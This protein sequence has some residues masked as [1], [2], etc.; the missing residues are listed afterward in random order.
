MASTFE[1]ACRAIVQK[2]LAGEVDDAKGL[3]SAKLWASR[4]FKLL[5]VPSN[6]Q[7][8]AQAS[9]QEKGKLLQLL[10]RK[11]VR[12]ASGVSII[13]VMTEPY[14]CPQSPPCIYCPGG[15]SYGTPQSYT[16]HEPAGLRAIQ[17]GFN[18][19]KQVRARI[20]QLQA[21]GHDVDKVELIVLGGTQ[22]AQP[23][24]Y[25]KWFT[26]EC[27]NALAGT[28]AS[29]IEEAQEAAERASIRNV[30]ITFETRPDY[31]KE[32]HVDLLL[33]L[34]ATRVELGVQTVY[35]DIYKFIKRGHT[36]KDVAEATRILKDSG[37]AIIY[38]MMP[39]LPG[40]D[41]DRDLDMFSKLF[42]DPSFRPDGLKIYPCLVIRGT[43]LHGRWRAGKF[44]AMTAEKA[45]K[46]IA[47]VKRSMPKWVRVHRIQRDIPAKLIEAGV[48]RGNLAQ[49]VEGELEKLGAR[50]RCIRCR[51][52]GLM[53]LRKGIQ[54]KLEDVKLL[55]ESYGASEGEEIFLSFEDVE[56]DIL[57]GFLR[58]RLPS[59]KAHYPKVDENIAVVRELHVY[60]PL[61]PVGKEAKV[62]DW[63]HRGW[64]E[65]LLKEAERAARERGARKI[66]ILSGIG[67]RNY[68]RRFD[69]RRE[70]PYMVKELS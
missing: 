49:M 6:V 21:I 17:E 37:F 58:L 27:L 19:H 30:G 16:G 66:A 65:E 47:E 20:G 15:P 39:G 62:G 48:K 68:Y 13:T 35:D 64:G 25:L 55:E 7:I 43:E 2:I 4:E 46:L 1:E 52:V 67:V 22:L 18:P 59:A 28:R 57:I 3:N 70:G 54:P 33:E 53:T 31:A 56:R 61:V 29:T 41:R 23:P 44:K 36:V 24:E 12:T 8:L 9:E 42:E 40:S 60:G 45:A 10:R 14:P 63:Q 50:C 69:Y 11:P 26:R 5:Q 32:K 34:G 51:E 38:H